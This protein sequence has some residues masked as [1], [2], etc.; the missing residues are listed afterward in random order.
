MFSY[1]FPL[2]LTNAEEA[3]KR[4]HLVKEA[5][6]AP[7]RSTTLKSALLNISSASIN[8]SDVFNFFSNLKIL[9][10]GFDCGEIFFCLMPE[11]VL[12]FGV[13]F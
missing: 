4:L 5:I 12:S 9:W 6:I 1:Q 8:L 13:N 3:K 2:Q 7:K 10:H 11:L